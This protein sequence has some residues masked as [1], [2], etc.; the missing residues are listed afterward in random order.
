[1]EISNNLVKEIQKGLLLWYNFKPSSYI[2]YIGNEED[3][4]AQFL[5]EKAEELICISI[6]DSVNM[7]T[8]KINLQYFDYLVSVTN[9]EICK[10]PERVLQCWKSLV[11][12]RGRLLLGMNNRLGLRYFCGDRDPYTNRNFDGIENYKGAYAKAEDIFQGRMYDKAQIKKMFEF[13]GLDTYQFFSVLTDLHNPTFIFSEEYIPNEDLSKRVFPT[14]NYPNTIFLQENNLYQQLIDNGMFH[15]MANAYL[16]ECSLDGQLC[17]VDHVT[18][19]LERG[20][21]DALYT[22]IYKSGRVEKRAAYPEGQKRLQ[23]LYAHNEELKA[24]GIQVIDAVLKEESYEMPYIEAEVGQSYLRRLLLSD[25]RRFLE[26]MDHFRDLIL[27]SSPIVKPDLGDGEG[28]ILERGFIDM[29]PLNSFRINDSFV[30]FDQEFSEANYPANTLLWRMVA[31]F[32]EGDMEVHNLLPMDELLERYDL[33]RN[34]KKWQN[35]EWDFLRELRKEKKLNGYHQKIRVNGNILN[36]NRQRM[37]YSSDEYQKLFVDIFKN[38][39]TRKL[40]LFGSGN[41]TK[42]FLAC[43][44]KDYPVYA[45]LDNNAERWG[46]EIDGIE[47]QSPEILKSFQ[48]GEYK[49]IIC[50]KNYLSVMKQLDEMGV[51]DYSIYDWNIDYPRKLKP[52]VAQDNNQDD[53][54]KRYHVG[55]VAGAF[56]MFHIG[57]LNLL[58]RAKEMCDYLIVGIISDESIYDLKKKKPI[59][60]CSERV[61]VVAGC[62]YVDQ[63]EALPTDYA[64]IRD[65]YKMFHFDC[66]FTG[67]DHGDDEGWLSDQEYLKKQGA[68]IVFFPYT[69][70]TSSTKIREDINRSSER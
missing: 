46:Q 40:I 12:P 16:I 63:A 60:P 49:V 36:S 18:S 35:M 22:I 52:I 69:R 43:Y 15:K 19:S 9:L 51:G 21:E 24:N 31:T 65:A 28:A 57:H 37:N 34:L 30:F 54:P 14:Y 56:D 67:D 50:I 53:V 38:A 29:V 26:E 64:G 39:D 17:D 13:A 10:Q 2:L 66:Q 61:A 20:R 11:K 44:K 33:K 4:L 25:K 23:E 7:A 48:S 3:A 45:I 5:K 68:D 70:E 62:R 58:R 59:I 6:D 47:I 27:S 41:F 55:Y 8:E 1:M 32:Y 42:K